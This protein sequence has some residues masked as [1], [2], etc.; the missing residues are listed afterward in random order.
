MPGGVEL[1]NLGLT[2]TTLVTLVY[3]DHDWSTS[4][5]RRESRDFLKPKK[6]VEL[7]DTGYFSF[8][9]APEKSANIIKSW[10]QVSRL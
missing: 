6:Y 9:D 7:E 1:W 5:E 4:E 3:G 8:L 10:P 2:Q